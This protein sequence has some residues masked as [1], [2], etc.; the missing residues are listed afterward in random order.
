M[1]RVSELKLRLL[2]P[3]IPMKAEANLEAQVNALAEGEVMTFESRCSLIKIRVTVEKAQHR[4]RALKNS[5]LS[6]EPT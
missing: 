4:L 2:T 1:S 3:T 6:Y 5:Y